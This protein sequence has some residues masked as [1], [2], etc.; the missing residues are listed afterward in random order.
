MY[1]CTDRAR[2]TN[3]DGQTDTTETHVCISPARQAGKQTHLH[4][5]ADT[6]TSLA[7]YVTHTCIKSTGRQ[8]SPHTRIDPAIPHAPPHARIYAPVPPSR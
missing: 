3:T 2:Q 6:H 8:A 1:V 4:R 5:Q 7:T